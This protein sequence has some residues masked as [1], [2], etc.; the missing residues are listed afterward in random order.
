LDV[1]VVEA[2]LEDSEHAQALVDLIDSYARGPGGQLAPLTPEARANLVPG[3]RRHP[4]ALVLL[5]VA[6]GEAAGAAVCF[7]GFS[8]FAGR[9]LL[10]IH[11]LV[12]FPQYQNRGI[13]SDLLAEAERL[14]RE[15]GCCK[16]T[17]EVHDTNADAKRLYEKFGFGP[18]S[19][20]TIYVTKR[21]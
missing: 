16:L 1:Q 21:L 4:S 9:L 14:A 3:L 11:D 19:P 5:A 10:N 20:T 15:R 17:L 7:W 13:G 8:T 18:W 2:K 12:V 6:D